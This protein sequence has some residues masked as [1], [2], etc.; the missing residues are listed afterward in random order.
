MTIKKPFY[1]I[2]F[3]FLAAYYT[4]THALELTHGA[5]QSSERLCTFNQTKVPLL[6]K[7][8]NILCFDSNQPV[9]LVLKSGE[10]G[11]GTLTIDEDGLV[12]LHSQKLGRLTFKQE[13]IAKITLI[14]E[15]TP[16]TSQSLTKIQ[17]KGVKDVKIAQLDE[18][19][20]SK[21]E[22][23]EGEE[24]DTDTPETI[25]EEPD[26]DLRQIFL[27][28]STVLLKP[29][30]TEFDIS[31]NYTRNEAGNSRLRNIDIPISLRIGLTQR[32]EGF[33]NIPWVWAQNEWLR[34]SGS[35]L[36]V[37]KDHAVGLGD[38]RAGLKYL[39]AYQDKY[40]PDIIGTLSVN[41]PTGEEPDPNNVTEATIGSGHWRLSAYLTFVKSYDPAV[42]FGGIGYTHTFEEE[43]GGIN[44]T[45]GKRFHYNFGMGFALNSQ[46]SL[47][48]QFL[49]TYQT[50]TKRDDVA[51]TDLSYDLMS[52][53]TG[54][55]YRI[56]KNRYLEPAVIYGLNDDAT[57][58][59]LTL[60]Y[61]QRLN[62]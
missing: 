38:I 13:D 27:R 55:T 30:E 47:S 32:L 56:A 15:K 44:I 23:K 45:P 19:E 33:I 51:S 50:E 62:F 21:K 6:T 35:T 40:K 16:L 1:I 3:L 4:T 34:F 39:L 10:K 52:F 61:T 2:F 36:V 14:E 17:A 5:Q 28:Q 43:R 49:G 9:T 29:G 60:S 57:D 58:V 18:E 7:R 20:S 12:S 53:K 54:L 48:G 24:D 22:E 41:F 31:L 59:T 42:L 8:N 11:I 37:D 26:E 25:G 46:I